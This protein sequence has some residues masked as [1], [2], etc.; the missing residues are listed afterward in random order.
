MTLADRRARYVARAKRL[1]VPEVEARRLFAGLLGTALKVRS[2]ASSARAG[3][4][5]VGRLAAVA[6]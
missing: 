6:S 1:G 2:H 3:H 4:A 5:R